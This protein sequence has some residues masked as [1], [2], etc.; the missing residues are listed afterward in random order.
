MTETTREDDRIF[1][2]N[3]VSERRKVDEKTGWMR[4]DR[5]MKRK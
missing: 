2:C 5:A 3:Q 1:R 4:K